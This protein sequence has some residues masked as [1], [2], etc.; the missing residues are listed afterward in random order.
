MRF[1]MMMM[2]VVIA[3]KHGKC[4]VI[5]CDALVDAVRNQPVKMVIWTR[6]T[7][8]EAKSRMVTP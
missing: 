3:A 2:L 5:C 4:N 6:G 7:K 1:Q 8:H